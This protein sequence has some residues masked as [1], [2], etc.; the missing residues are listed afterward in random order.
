MKHQSILMILKNLRVK[1][2]AKLTCL[3]VI[4]AELRGLKKNRAL[5]FAKCELLHC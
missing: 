3:N 1:K 5:F 2:K 4:F